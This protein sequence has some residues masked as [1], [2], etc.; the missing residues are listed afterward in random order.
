MMLNRKFHLVEI[1]SIYGVFSILLFIYLNSKSSYKDIP[2]NIS[3]QKTDKQP[4]KLENS[5]YDMFDFEG[6]DN[7]TGSDRL[8]V[9]NIVH[10]IYLNSTEIKFYQAINIYSIFLNQK[11]EKIFIHCDN[12][13]FSG[14]YWKQINSIKELSEV[15]KI[16]QIPVKDKIFGIKYGYIEHRFYYLYIIE[17]I[18]I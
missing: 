2:V 8:I 5:D 4:F 11:P 1:I 3:C 18:G 13:S 10:L 15:L 17:M 14:H 9:P 6:F 16:N 12:C 7:Q